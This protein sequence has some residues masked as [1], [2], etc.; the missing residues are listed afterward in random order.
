[1]YVHT[2][3]IK[4]NVYIIKTRIFVEENIF[5][6]FILQKCSSKFDVLFNNK[7]S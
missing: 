2:H 1:M 7:T 6:S 4:S 3:Y 5:T